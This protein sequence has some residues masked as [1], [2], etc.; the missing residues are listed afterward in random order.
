MR[1]LFAER[2]QQQVQGLG[3]QHH[4]QLQRQRRRSLTGRDRSR[5]LRPLSGTDNDPLSKTVCFTA[6]SLAG[7]ADLVGINGTGSD[8]RG[9]L[10]ALF[11]RLPNLG[12]QLLSESFRGGNKMKTAQSAPEL[13]WLLDGGTGKASGPGPPVTTG[14]RN[15]IRRQD[16]PVVET[17]K[18]K[19]VAP[20]DT[21]EDNY[22]EEDINDDSKVITSSGMTFIIVIIIGTF[23]I[24]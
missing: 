10:L 19:V 2:N 20:R 1:Q 18:G 8:L 24:F 17:K 12:G 9:E 15:D 23:Y 4:Q 22:D 13:K 5:P 21:D 11:G 6:P 3:Y 16:P 14:S 7:G